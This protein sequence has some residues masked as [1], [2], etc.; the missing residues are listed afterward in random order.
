MLRLSADVY[1]LVSCHHGYRK[2]QDRHNNVKDQDSN[3]TLKTREC[4][5]TSITDAVTVL[6]SFWQKLKEHYKYVL[7]FSVGSSQKTITMNKMYKGELSA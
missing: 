5:E 2:C 6:Y 3:N 1:T 7:S 4:H